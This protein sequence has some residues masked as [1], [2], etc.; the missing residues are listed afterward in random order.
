[1]HLAMLYYEAITD[2]KSR[3]VGWL[4]RVYKLLWRKK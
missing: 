3:K 1:M 4:Q 2:A